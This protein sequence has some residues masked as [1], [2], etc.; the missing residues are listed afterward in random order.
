MEF[1]RKN[2]EETMGR[3][4]ERTGKETDMRERV[5]V[6]EIV[7]VTRQENQRKR[8]EMKRERYER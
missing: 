3:K 2:G 5:D 4:G 8:E 7:V 1:K 6:G